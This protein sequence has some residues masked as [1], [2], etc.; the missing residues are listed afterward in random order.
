MAIKPHVRAWATLAG[1]LLRHGMVGRE[2]IARVSN[3]AG[4]RP[5][6]PRATPDSWKGAI[7]RNWTDGADWSTDQF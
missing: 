4:P 6:P 1:T 2:Q 7:S 3:L 5:A